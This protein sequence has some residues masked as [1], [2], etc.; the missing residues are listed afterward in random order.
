MIAAEW[1]ITNLQMAELESRIDGDK[2]FGDRIDKYRVSLRGCVWE[3]VCM[4]GWMRGG[5]GGQ[6]RLGIA[7]SAYMFLEGPGVPQPGVSG[8]A[9]VAGPCTRMREE[10]RYSVGCTCVY[11]MRMP[12]CALA[13]VATGTG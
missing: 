3:R 9:T 2:I 7:A 10:R 13:E 8:C 11:S 5:G 4:D 12:T 6:K 1:T